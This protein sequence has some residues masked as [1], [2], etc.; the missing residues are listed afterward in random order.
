MV[1]ACS[2]KAKYFVSKCCLTNVFRISDQ[3]EPQET[4]DIKS[5]QT[6]NIYKHVQ[7]NKCPAESDQQSI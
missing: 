6:Q 2:Q 1:R 4:E 5:Q 3:G 7:H